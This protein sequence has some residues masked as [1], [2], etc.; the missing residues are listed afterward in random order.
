MLHG[1]FRISPLR[2]SDPIESTPVRQSKK[3]EDQMTNLSQ[4]GQKSPPDH[5]DT[6]LS[7]HLLAGVQTESLGY[8]GKLVRLWCLRRALRNAE[9]SPEEA[10]RVAKVFE[11]YLTGAPTAAGVD[12]ASLAKAINASLCEM[13]AAEAQGGKRTNSGHLGQKIG[14]GF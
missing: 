7:N 6:A 2:Q 5:V 11:S 12:G 8:E 10:V 13:V 1:I 9:L 14:G 3:R 4:E